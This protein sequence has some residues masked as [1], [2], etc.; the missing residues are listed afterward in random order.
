MLRCGCP[1]SAE[2]VQWGCGRPSRVD[3]RRC[4]VRCCRGDLQTAFNSAGRDWRRR[5][6][7]SRDLHERRDRP[8]CSAH[9]RKWP[10]RGQAGLVPAHRCGTAAPR[11]PHG[12]AHRPDCVNPETPANSRTPDRSMD[13]GIKPHCNCYRA[14]PRGHGKIRRSGPSHMTTAAEECIVPSAG[15]GA[16]AEDWHR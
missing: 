16:V 10:S 8:C 4:M 2:A 15:E 11:S 14:L 12:R 3:V 9:G 7:Q 5:C 1:I 13:D 6:H